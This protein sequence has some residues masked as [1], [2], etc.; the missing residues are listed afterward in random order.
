MANGW[1][2]G[3][4]REAMLRRVAIVLSSLPAPVASQLLSAVDP[5]SRR[6]FWEALFELADAGTTVLVSTPWA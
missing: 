1:N 4:E 3:Q 2:S 5:E 6:D